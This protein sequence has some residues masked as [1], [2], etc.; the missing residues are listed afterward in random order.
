MLRTWLVR[1]PA[2]WLTLSVRSFQVPAT[3]G[4][5]DWPPSLPSTPTSRATRVTSDANEA[6]R[7]TIAFTVLAMRRYSPE[8]GRPATSSSTLW[9][10]C[11][12]STASRPRV[13][14]RT[15]RV[16]SSSKR[17]IAA[18]ISDHE[19]PAPP[20]RAFSSRLPSRP[21]ERARRPSS[22]AR[23]WCSS[24][25]SL[26]A[27]AMR[28]SIPSR[29][30]GRRMLKSP[31]F[32]ASSASSS[33]PLSAMSFRKVRVPMDP[34]PRC[35]E[36]GWKTTATRPVRSAAPVGLLRP[37]DADR[38]GASRN[39]GIRR[40]PGT[41]TGRACPWSGG[42]PRPSRS[43]AVPACSSWTPSPENEHAH[44][45]SALVSAPG[46]RSGRGP[47]ALSGR[48]I[49]CP[50]AS[51]AL[52]DPARE[53]AHRPAHARAHGALG[54]AQVL[55]QRAVVLLEDLAAHDE[56]ALLVVEAIQR[57]LQELPVLEA[58]DD[59]RGRAGI[60]AGDVLEIVAVQGAQLADGRASS[61]ARGLLAQGVH[62]DPHE[63]GQE[64]ALSAPL[65]SRQVLQRAADGLLQDFLLVDEKTRLSRQTRA[66]RAT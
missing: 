18:P 20:M 60:G 7:L 23:R 12:F 52:F 66:D 65:E 21:T 31:F 25:S 54:D 8:S 43:R 2:I 58:L 17:S 63:P 42:K 38:G 29:S 4:N 53:L 44:R 1:L 56:R 57:I 51:D 47:R 19:P 61:G 45:G 37:N 35:A 10:S 48:C 64:S 16:R 24:A 49:R 41:R 36:R 50:I 55:R 13:T 33:R 9:S 46:P 22:V 5:F 62:R 27:S 34:G 40:A 15:G 6:R 14:S 32:S 11:P 3:P 59:A 26:K 28:P 39:P 30:R